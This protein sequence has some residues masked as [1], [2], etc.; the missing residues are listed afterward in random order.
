MSDETG[1]K[2][3]FA[4]LQTPLTNSEESDMEVMARQV[5]FSV[6][7]ESDGLVYPVLG[8]EFQYLT[9]RE[10]NDSLEVVC[11]VTAGRIPVVAGVAAYFLETE[12]QYAGPRQLD[13]VDA[14]TSNLVQAVLSGDFEAQVDWHIGYDQINA[15]RVFALESPPRVVVDMCVEDNTAG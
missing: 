13:G 8:G 10:R 4:V 3:I 14:G 15:F 11:D 9:E 12:D 6:E 2:G 1:W 5:E 7:C